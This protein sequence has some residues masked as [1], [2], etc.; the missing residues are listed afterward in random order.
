MT[1]DPDGS[2][3]VVE[4]ERKFDVGEADQLPSFAG[5]PGVAGVDD[6]VEYRLDA[7]YFDTPDLAL[8]ARHLTLRRRTGGSDAGWHLKTPVRAD[9][10]REFQEPLGDD[11]EKVPE[12]LMRLV[13]VYVRDRPL[14]P[15]VRLRTRRLVYRLHDSHGAVLAEVS[16]DRVHADRLVSGPSRSSWREWEIELVGGDRPLLDA[17]QSALEAQGVRLSGSVSK[18]ARALGDRLPAALPPEVQD[19]R[20]GS[21]GWVLLS[22]LG[23]QARMLWQQDPLVRQDE[24]DA[25]HRMRVATRRI[26]SALKSYGTLLDP[27]TAQRL[28]SELGSL[29]GILGA[30]R[31]SQMLR[32]RLRDRIAN[33]PAVE[34]VSS[35]IDEQLG[36]DYAAARIDVLEAL[37]G[38]RYFRLLDALDTLLTAPPLTETA[39]EPAVEIVPELLGREWKRLRKAVKAAKKTAEGDNRDVALHKA[40]KAAKRVR[41]AAESAAL[42]YG[43][44]AL[45]LAAAAEEL[46]TILGDHQDSVVARRLLQDWGANPQSHDEGPLSYDRLDAIERK[47]AADSEARFFRAWS[48]ARGPSHKL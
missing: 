16:D 2:A 48:V 28:R 5:L 23:D 38:D 33:E 34:P 32:Q 41:Y 11:P 40:R 47:T 17:A 10:R 37:D 3:E 22:Y 45:R 30:A 44:P 18:L 35:Q 39:L 27:E 19:G 26:R 31:D 6:P 20:K 15:A 42:L 43:K 4:I 46:Q 1:R 7:V 9:A 24:P 21:A 12:Q 13:R 29:A 14:A 25:L 36:A 8:S